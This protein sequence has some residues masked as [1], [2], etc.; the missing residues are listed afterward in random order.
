MKVYLDNAATTK[1]DEKVRKAMQPYFSE[2]FGN[3]SSKHSL[4]QEAKMALEE[5][6]NV[7]AKSIHAKPGEIFFTGSGTES[8]NWTIKGVGLSGLLSGKKHIIT[9]KIEHDCILNSCKWMEKQG[10]EVTY[11]DVDADGFVNPKD[12][13]DAI[14]DET[15]L[16]SVIHGNNEIG[17]I[18][19]IDSIGKICKE[20]NVY[21]HIDACQSYTKVPIDVRKQNLD[22]VTLN[23]HKI[24]GPKGVGA[25]YIREG[26]NIETFI[27]GGNQELGMRSGTENIAGIVGFAMAVNISS[28][29]NVVKMT[30]L[31]DRLIDDILKIPHSR[32]NGPSGDKRLC[33]NL[34]FSFTAIDGEAIGAY[35]DVN[36]ICSSNG[37]A[38]SSHKLQTSHVLQAI[39]VDPMDANGSI[40]L[41]LDKNNSEEEVD[42][43]VKN[44]TK[45]V[46]KLRKMS[47]FKLKDGKENN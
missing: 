26:T 45:I 13:R 6:R 5:S 39:G 1:V 33:N 23:A 20:K 42:Y 47:P 30:R 37:S 2:K 28:Y 34:N 35:L 43:V 9:T 12:V 24:N 31:R 21:F 17:T 38:C 8:N 46:L 29:K 10:F 14:R 4:G 18:Q 32:L 19:D 22:L 15:V 7:I 16:V 44:L 25:L 36:G 3:A 41:S 40:R 27:H 11:L